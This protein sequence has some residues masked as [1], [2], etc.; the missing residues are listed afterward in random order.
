MVTLR[1]RETTASRSQDAGTS[2]A[3]QDPSN[4]RNRSRITTIA[5]T[6]TGS[7]RRS[8]SP[9]ENGDLQAIRVR[10]RQ[11]EEMAELQAREQS[12]R[13][14][15]Q[16]VQPSVAQGNPRRRASD[17]SSKSSREDSLKIT[18][19]ITFTD[20]M[21]Y[22]RRQE[23]LQDLSRAFAGAPRK[24]KKDKKRIIFALD[25]MSEG[26]RNRWF[27]H[28][29]TLATPERD[30]FETSWDKFD[31]WT[32]S[33]IQDSSDREAS[34]AKQLEAA[35]QRDAQSP[36]DFHYFLA[37][38]ESQLP[39]QN[40][41][42]R[43]LLF[44][45]KLQP[46]LVAHI[47]LYSGPQKPTTREGMVQLADRYWS[48]M[49]RKRKELSSRDD[50]EAP[51]KRGRYGFGRTRPT[52]RR[53]D[54]PQRPVKSEESA[55]PPTRDRPSG[56]KNPL[57]ANGNPLKCY[58]C[59]SEYHFAPACPKASTVGNTMA[60]DGAPNQGRRRGDYRG[61]RGSRG[62]YPGNA[63]APGRQATVQRRR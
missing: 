3:T 17:A 54:P 6:T 45:T 10:I 33:C 48:N 9:P 12:L 2:A 15:L 11:L 44:Y 41:Q 59:N 46:E 31:D 62:S 42:Q 29:D 36:W 7:S 23:W 51:A 39:R 22:R 60:G 4:P 52:S 49:P 20:K 18:N 35:R 63:R 26:P 37:S 34:L 32:L 30:T 43:A 40:E 28:R 58:N 50:F 47:D 56:E 55:Q 21:S 38:L 5:S 25:Y 53:S 57:D 1:R 19:I 24:F 27:S 8:P 13:D 61:N 16:L 14:Q